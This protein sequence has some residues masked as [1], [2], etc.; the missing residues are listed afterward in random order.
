M[1]VSGNLT[2]KPE[3][4]TM[5]R[6]TNELKSIIVCNKINGLIEFNLLNVWFHRTKSRENMEG[7]GKVSDY[8]AG[9]LDLLFVVSDAILT[10]TRQES[11]SYTK[12]SFVG[13]GAG[14]ALVNENNNN[15]K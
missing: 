2:R 1:K 7:S 14:G 4:Q 11:R 13:G 3:I 10:N 6:M 9:I 8:N 15:K 12:T 5:K